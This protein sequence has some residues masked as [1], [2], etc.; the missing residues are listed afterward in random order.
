MVGGGA[1][2]VG[3]LRHGLGHAHYAAFFHLDHDPDDVCVEEE[4]EGGG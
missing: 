4:E 3:Q 1:V 2:V